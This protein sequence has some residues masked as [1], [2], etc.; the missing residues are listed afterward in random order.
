MPYGAAPEHLGEFPLDLSEVMY[1]LYLP[2]MM[3]CSP[4]PRL[5]SNVFRFW[6]LIDACSQ[7]AP[8]RYNYVYLSARKGWATP[9]NPL[10]RP[11]FHCDGFGTDDLNYVWWVGPGTRFAIQ[12]FHD[13][14]D[15]HVESLRQFE[16]QIDLYRVV[17][18]L[19]ERN[20]YALTPDVVHATPLIR[21]PGCMRQYVKVSLARDRAERYPHRPAR[22]C[23]LG[24]DHPCLTLP[25]A[26]TEPLTFPQLADPP[27]V[28][29][30]PISSQ[31][32][33]PPALTLPPIFTADTEAS[34]VRCSR[35][36]STILTSTTPLKAP[37]WRTP[38]I[39]TTPFIMLTDR[40][41]N[42]LPSITTV[43]T[44]SFPSC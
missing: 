10:N 42:D 19:P 18:D 43:A 38:S 24:A 8:R 9:D 14:S 33:D 35:L 6:K 13:I 23:G 34:V 30:P 28:T 11:G 17:S 22:L 29:E 3:P 44:A 39:V 5:P 37:S 31:L 27:A 40:P 26:M 25:P 1:Y 20:L 4:E 36:P 16:D 41:E 2:V 21:P 12:K 7:H 15:D 32:T